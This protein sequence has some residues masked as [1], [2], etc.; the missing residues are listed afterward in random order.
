[1]RLQGLRALL[2]IVEHGSFSEAALELGV[3][4]STVSH[5]I[6]EL[7]EELG[8]RLL[9]RGRFGAA[10]TPVGQ[11]VAHHARLVES[12][13]AAIAQEATTQREELRGELRVSAIRS[14]A[15]HVLAPVMSSLRETHPGLRVAVSE[16][17]SWAR[18]PLVDLRSAR[19]DVALTMSS[20]AEDVLYWQLVRD[21]YVAVVRDDDGARGEP[22]SLRDLVRQ[23]V[24]ISGGPCCWPIRG[25]LLDVDPTFRPA[26]EIG[27]DSTMLALV[28]RGLGVALMPA[29]TVDVL[30]PGTRALELAETVER[31]VGVAVLPR[32]LKTPAVRVFLER[33]REMF[34]ASGLP[35][36]GGATDEPTTLGDGA[37]PEAAAR[38][39]SLS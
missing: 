27:E 9:E 28:A 16:V 17:S 8:V 13:L 29:L 12:A 25:A 19:A 3:S 32:S 14:L 4:Q 26:Y 6:A 10:P 37:E 7:E 36:L 2:A 1:M 35:P 23:P 33:L 24:I 39:M 5:A 38:R 20:Q 31:S 34:P 30:P 18:D 15:V 21:P 22:A 11:R